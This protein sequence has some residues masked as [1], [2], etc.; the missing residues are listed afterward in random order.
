MPELNNPIVTFIAVALD[1][2]SRL[3]IKRA[4]KTAEM[5]AFAIQLHR[6]LKTHSPNSAIENKRH[7]FTFPSPFMEL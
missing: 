2:I 7:K 4:R 1:K 6:D 5:A 3:G